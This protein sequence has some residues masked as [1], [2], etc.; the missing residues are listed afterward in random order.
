MGNDVQLLE[1]AL[2]RATEGFR[3]MGKQDA[4]RT[5]SRPS[6]LMSPAGCSDWSIERLGEIAQSATRHPRDGVTA[7]TLIGALVDH[8]RAPMSDRGGQRAN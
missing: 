2:I 4:H 3:M 6:D 5:L 1:E 7:T 8:A